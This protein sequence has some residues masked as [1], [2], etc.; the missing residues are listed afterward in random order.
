MSEMGGS[1][2]ILDFTK[3]RGF[4]CDAWHVGRR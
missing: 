1:A 3:L 2:R 4:L